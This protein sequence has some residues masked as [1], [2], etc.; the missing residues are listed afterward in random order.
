LWPARLRLR[1]ETGDEERLLTVAPDTKVLARCR[2]HP[3]RLE[4]PTLVLWH[5]MEGSIA[6]TYMLT[7]AAKAFRAGFNVV[8]VNIRNCGATEHLTPTLYHGGLSNDLRAVLNELINEDRLPQIL[9]GG[10]SLGGNKVL[11]LAGEYGQNPPPQLL[12]VCAV[13][14]SINLRA[15]SDLLM[16]PRNWIYHQD[17]LYFLKRRIRT[18]EK[19]FPELFDSSGLRGIRT[20]EEFDS[21][22]IAPRFG[23]ADVNDYYAKASALPVMARIHVPTLI[24]HAADDPF[25]PIEPVRDPSVTGN[26][27]ILLIETEH[28]GHV[29]F[30]SDEPRQ[31]EDRFWAENRLID[32]CKILTA[33]ID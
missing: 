30:V 19:L 33:G 16:R 12:G 26:P 14:P 21:R 11:K 2:W 8:R 32:F 28:G 6:S 22:Y 17:F 31:D 7:T 29:A 15:G 1:D 18:K 13:S 24:I 3:A 27:Y 9:I 4:H 5:G 23:F 25:I 10:F 20:I